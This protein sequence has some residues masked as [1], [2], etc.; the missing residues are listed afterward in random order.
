[1]TYVLALN[2]S[3][4]GKN[5]NT[6]ALLTPF[7]EGATEAGATVETVVVKDLD[8][9]FCRGCFTCW[10]ATPGKCCQKDDMEGLLEKF[11]R[12]DYVV[13]ATPLYHFGMT[14]LL[15]RVLE[16]TLPTLE[17]RMIERGNRTSHPLREGTKHWRMVL[18][19]NCGFP[20]RVH[21]DAL[22]DHM[23][24]VMGLGH[25]L[26]ATILIGGG[27]ALRRAYNPDGPFGWVFDAMRQAGRE[28][29]TEGALSPE[30]AEILAR[31]LAPSDVYR[32]V[33]NESWKR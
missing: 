19:S 8:I 11:R 27:E 16:R 29:V 23:R 30:T 12:A 9:G 5:S 4:R 17:P 6:N 22:V 20:E 26:A 33:V 31:Q 2:G 21:F 1:M 7:L 15:K 32:A 25:G 10:S 28:V 18:L 13:F 14:A 24:H 3:P